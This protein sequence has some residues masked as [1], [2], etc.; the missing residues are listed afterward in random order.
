MK[1]TKKQLTVLQ[2][3]VGR[4]QMRYNHDAFEQNRSTN[5]M[6]RAKIAGVH[7]CGERFGI[8]DGVLAVLFDEKPDEFVDAERMDILDK[9][10]RG[11]IED[12]DLYLVKELLALKLAKGLLL[13]GKI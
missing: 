12:G 10:A 5:K 9:Y 3:I 4:E 2:K 13:N 1:L 6:Q 7:P 8:T 11:F